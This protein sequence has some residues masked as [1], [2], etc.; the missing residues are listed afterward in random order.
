LIGIAHTL[1]TTRA[2]AKMPLDFWDEAIRLFGV[3]RPNQQVDAALAQRPAPKAGKAVVWKPAITTVLKS[4]TTATNRW[5]GRNLTLGKLPE[6]SRKISAWP[7]P[8]DSVL[9]KLSGNP[10]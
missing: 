5:L 4:P 1:A 2:A 7:R 3:T 8:P 9:L 10:G 6:V